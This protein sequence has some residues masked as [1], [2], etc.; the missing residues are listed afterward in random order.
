LDLIGKDTHF[1]ESV[2]GD[3]DD[4]VKKNELKTRGGCSFSSNKT[5]D[6]KECRIVASSNARRRQTDRISKTKKDIISLDP[7]KQTTTTTTTEDDDDDKQSRNGTT[8]RKEEKSHHHPPDTHND[9]TTK[10]ETTTKAR[11]FLGGETTTC[12]QE[13][14]NI[15]DDVCAS[16]MWMC[17]L[18][19]SLFFLFFVRWFEKEIRV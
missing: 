13:E 18:F 16:V 6:R 8:N 2:F 12:A 3:D 14:A 5:G 4:D 7:H 1:G 15:L 9:A 10:T 11:T 17:R 19:L